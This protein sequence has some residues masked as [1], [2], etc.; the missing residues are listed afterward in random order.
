MLLGTV[1]IAAVLLVAVGILVAST[2]P[3]GIQTLVAHAGISSHL[4]GWLHGPLADYEWKGLSSEWARKASA[5]F[6]GL[7]LLYGVC[8]LTGRL[9][10][11]TR[12]GS[13]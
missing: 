7:A 9:V 4:P 2:A 8:L 1:A 13:V 5:G 11:R 3:D 10:G 12:Q 6:T